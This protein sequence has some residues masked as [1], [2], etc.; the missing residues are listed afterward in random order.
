MEGLMR[1]AIGSD[2]AGF[3][4]K[5]YLIDFLARV[6]LGY[7]LIDKGTY[8]AESCDYPVYA[9][10]VAQAVV[11]NECDVGILI[12]GTG[13]G[14]AIAAN[15]ISGIRAAVSW[16]ETVAALAKEHNNANILCVGVR[17]ADA[18][19]IEESILTW[20]AAEFDP[21]HQPRVYQIHKLEDSS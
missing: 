13:I 15:K 5:Q 1:I 6:G 12:C 18:L 9:K 3:E 11:S 21:R 14:M 16:N 7:E 10:L 4:A 2:H 19:T 8:S 20:L 17:T